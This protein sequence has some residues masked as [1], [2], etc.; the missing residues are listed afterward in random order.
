MWD[1]SRMIPCTCM[2]FIKNSSDSLE[3]LLWSLEH[4]RIGDWRQND[5]TLTH[6]PPTVAL[7]LCLSAIGV[8]ERGRTRV[9]SIHWRVRA[10]LDPCAKHSLEGQSEAWLV[11]WAF[12]GGSERGLARGVRLLFGGRRLRFLFVWCFHLVGVLVTR[13]RCW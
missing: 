8:P 3:S 13:T 11:Y 7:W 2:Y 9:L 6:F 1:R 5:Q 10:R 4:R 12:I